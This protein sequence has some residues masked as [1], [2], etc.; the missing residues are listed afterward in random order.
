MVSPD[1]VLRRLEKAYGSLPTPKRRDPLDELVLTV[2]SQNTSDTNRDRAW[3]SLRARYRTWRDVA[4]APVADVVAT[5]RVGGLA[6]TK[7][8]RI[9]AILKAIEAERGTIDL[10]FLRRLPDD[11]VHAFLRALPGVGP[12]T[13][14]CVLAFALR[15]PVIP[16]DTHVHRTTRRLG[17]ISPR[18]GAAAAHAELASVVRTEDRLP[19]H[20]ALI[21]H[22]R[23]TCKARRPACRTCVLVDVCPRVGVVQPAPSARGCR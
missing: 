8:P 2:L 10:R 6:A 9:Q 13:V 1:V 3:R 12:K 17:L 11:E 15:R 19:L 4:E 23:E 16:V 20:V 5:I 18:T 21:H 14:A 7:A 22:G